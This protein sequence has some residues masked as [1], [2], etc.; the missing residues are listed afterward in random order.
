MNIIIGLL[1]GIIA[2]IF[3][4][5]VKWRNEM[6]RKK[7]LASRPKLKR[8]PPSVQYERVSRY[9]AGGEIVYF[10]GHDPKDKPPPHPDEGNLDIL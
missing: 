10:P 5:W 6:I 8:A 3:I 1:T 9:K 7:I 4:K 2:L